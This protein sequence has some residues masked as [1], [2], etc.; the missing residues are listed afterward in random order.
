VN[1]RTESSEAGYASLP[2]CGLGIDGALKPRFD[3]SFEALKEKC[4]GHTVRFHLVFSGKRM[5]DVLPL[6]RSR[7][8][9][10]GALAP[11]F[12]PFWRPIGCGACQTHHLLRKSTPFEIVR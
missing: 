4:A 1:R 2:E 8:F 5:E 10:S 9:T 11:R 6:H 12:Y 7:D 3:E